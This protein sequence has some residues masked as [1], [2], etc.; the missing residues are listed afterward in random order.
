MF[1]YEMMTS[2]MITGEEYQYI[3]R[4]DED[5]VVSFVPI[6]ERNSDYQQYLLWLEEQA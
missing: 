4:I 2:Q 3:N 5:G 1:T 6:D